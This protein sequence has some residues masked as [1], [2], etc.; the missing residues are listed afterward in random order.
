MKDL[1]ETLKFHWWYVYDK[2]G[3]QYAKYG[4]ECYAKEIC[5]HP[6]YKKFGLYY[7]MGEERTA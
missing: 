6:D 2:N 5:E 7:K 1:N 3:N 4:Y